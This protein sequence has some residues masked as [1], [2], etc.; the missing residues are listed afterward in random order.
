[1]AI[2]PEDKINPLYDEITDNM[3][4]DDSEDKTKR[5][6]SNSSLFGLGNE[7]LDSLKP[8]LIEGKLDSEVLN[9][10]KGIILVKHSNVYNNNSKNMQLYHLPL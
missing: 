7:N 9:R 1:M 10:E 4:Q 5:K 8:F 6:M 2:V 3:W